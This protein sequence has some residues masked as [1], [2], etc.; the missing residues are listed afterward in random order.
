M[1]V[2][3]MQDRSTKKVK[4]KTMEERSRKLKVKKVK[5]KLK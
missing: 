1:Y 5:R 3:L 2:K 4:V